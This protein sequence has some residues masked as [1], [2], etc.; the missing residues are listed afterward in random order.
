MKERLLL[1]PQLEGRQEQDEEK[2]VV[3]DE[4]EGDRKRVEGF[5][6]R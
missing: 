4:E 1:T 3:E 5:V 6:P 2:E